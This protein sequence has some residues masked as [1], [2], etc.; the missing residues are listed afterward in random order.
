MQVTSINNK[1]IDKAAFKM[2][3]M[4]VREM[5]KP[6]LEEVTKSFNVGDSVD[7]EVYAYLLQEKLGEQIASSVNIQDSIRK[8]L[9]AYNPNNEA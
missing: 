3:E 9:A 6:L 2:T 7:S 5:L 1:N 8:Y 4:F